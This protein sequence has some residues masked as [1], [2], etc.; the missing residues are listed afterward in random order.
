MQY[1][2][3]SFDG[4][5]TGAR[6]LELTSYFGLRPWYLIKACVAPYNITTGPMAAAKEGD[7]SSPTSGGGEER[8]SIKGDEAGLGSSVK[9]FVAG[10]GAAVVGAGSAAAGAATGAASTV[11]A[12][13]KKAFSEE[14]EV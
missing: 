7:A 9:A 13:I 14:S 3:E 5:D 1:E 2:N 6:E 12:S 4:L 8:Q 11:T 10:A